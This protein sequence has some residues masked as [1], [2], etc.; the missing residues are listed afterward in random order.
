MYLLPI[1]ISGPGQINL[2]GKK[3]NMD[4]KSHQWFG[5]TVHSSGENGVIVVSKEHFMKRLTLSL[6][7]NFISAIFNFKLCFN[8]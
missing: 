5:A 6:K 8:F 7:L 4:D 2:R 1:C 3:E